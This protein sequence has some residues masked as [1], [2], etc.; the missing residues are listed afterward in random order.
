[1]TKKTNYTDSDIGVLKGI[2]PIQQRPGMYTSTETPNHMLGE[3]IDNARDEAMGGFAD[4]LRIEL[5][6]DGSLEVEDNGRGIPTGIHPEEKIPTVEV[7]FTI[8][9]SGGKFNKDVYKFSGG[10]HGVGVTVTNALSTRVDVTIY[11]DGYEHQIGFVN[12]AVAEPLRKKKLPPEQKDRHGTKVRAWPDPKYFD[13]PLQVAQIERALHAQA[14]LLPGVEVAWTRP[15]HEEVVWKFTDGI[16]EFLTQE[17]GEESVLVAP[18][19]QANRHFDKAEGIFLENEGFDLILA[20][21]EQGRAVRESYVNLIPTKDGGQHEA[22]L[23]A[24]LFSA[25]RA[26]MDQLGLVPPKV[27]VE[28]DDVWAKAS[29]ILSVRLAETAF[30]GQTK[31]KMTARKGKELVERLVSDNFVLWLNDHPDY[32]RA[33]GELVVLEA[34]RRQKSSMPIE[35]AKGHSAAV[36]P[37][38]LVDC[39]SNDG[40]LCELFLVEG[41]SAGGSAQQGRDKNTQAVL[42]LR[43]KVVNT[44]DLDTAQ[45]LSHAE[46]SDIS[47]AI[48][49]PPHMGKRLAEVDLSKLRYH[50]ILILADA[51]I[52]GFHIQ[53]LLA[54][55]FLRHFPALVE[56]GHIWIAQPPLYRVDAP[57]K[58]GAK[59]KARKLYALDEAALDRIRKDLAKEGVPDDKWRIQRF[60]GLGEMNP[61]QLKETTLDPSSRHALQLTVSNAAEVIETF[62]LMMGEKVEPRRRWM[63]EM[64]GTVEAD[65]HAG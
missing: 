30:A 52:D 48:G 18:L 19:F 20:F 49:I 57:G 58:K 6:D 51:D 21:Q 3:I 31:D 50:K 5:F 40:S 2:A 47:A 61:E 26:S 11:R 63:E 46:P 43:G 22:G 64:G 25:L 53:C 13:G 16:A 37:G 4:R 45:V 38:K 41:D 9:H 14:V 36:L 32:A 34:Q 27:K 42:P 39:L 17:L 35:R 55:L 1:M 62:E 44:W 10:L 12:G 29:F 65:L 60:K 23:K 33:I 28:A 54:T 24:G 56:G 59:E 15:G 7:I 8:P